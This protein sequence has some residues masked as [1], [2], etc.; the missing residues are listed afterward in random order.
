MSE[1]LLENSDLITAI[2]EVTKLMASSTEV[3]I[4]AQTTTTALQRGIVHLD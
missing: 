3:V 4:T 2:S 1:H